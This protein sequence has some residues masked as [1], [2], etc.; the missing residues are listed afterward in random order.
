MKNPTKVDDLLWYVRDDCLG[1]YLHTYQ[2]SVLQSLTSDSF[3]IQSSL[4][5]L[6]VCYTKHYRFNFIDDL[7]ILQRMLLLDATVYDNDFELDL[8]CLGYSQHI[9][10]FAPDSPYLAQDD[11]LVAIIN[12]PHSD[13]SCYSMVKYI[14]QQ[15]DTNKLIKYVLYQDNNNQLHEIY[16]NTKD[17]CR[18]LQQS[19]VWLDQLVTD[20]KD[21]SIFLVYPP[22]VCMMPNM[23][24]QFEDNHQIIRQECA[25]RW[26]ELSLLYFIG[27]KTRQKLHDSDVYTLNHPK[28]FQYLPSSSTALIQKIMLSKMF[29]PIQTKLLNFRDVLSCSKFVYFDVETTL[30]N[31][32]LLVN[33]VGLVYQCPDSFQWKYKEWHSTD[34]NY[35]I[36][37][38]KVWMETHVPDHTVVHY[39]SAD[40]VA[41]PDSMKKLDLYSTVTSSYAE[42][43]E[44]QALNI[45]NFK[46]KTVYK[47]ICTRVSMKHLYDG[48]IIKNGLQ[49]MKA[50]D[51]WKDTPDICESWLTDVIEYNRVDCLA[52]LMLHQYILDAWDWDSLSVLNP[53]S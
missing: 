15:M 7:P 53:A 22:K 34:D 47:N 26:K 30:Q 48:C 20:G 18:L 16:F 39:T 31:K 49:A 32:Q 19:Q 43:V 21:W 23:T 4:D 51:V 33:V 37:E 44:L 2:P 24:K 46:L 9:R 8:K 41:I 3:T 5:K 35:C 29:D 1:Q 10:H 11:Q 52:L 28:L 14:L 6:K 50:L 38:A 27:D 13:F 17:M 25:W 40:L 12:L 45:N 36:H 42:S